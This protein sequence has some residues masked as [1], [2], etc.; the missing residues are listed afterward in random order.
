MA[1][2]RQLCEADK[3]VSPNYLVISVTLITLVSGGLSSRATD[4]AESV[5]E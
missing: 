2:D 4:E 3:S 1:F 5:K